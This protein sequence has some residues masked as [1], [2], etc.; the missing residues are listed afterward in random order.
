MDQ[1]KC[2][3]N[4]ILLRKFKK[5]RLGRSTISGAGLGLF[6]AEPIEKSDLVTIY[7][8]EII[9]HAIDSIR[10]SMRVDLTF[11]NFSSKE[12]TIDARFMGNL[13]RFINHGD[14]GM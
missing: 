11:Y 7:A 8:G 9:D 12:G 10:E 14:N 1:S 4:S 3:N 13:S 6:A 2:K 5:V